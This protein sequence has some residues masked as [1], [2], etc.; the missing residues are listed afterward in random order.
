MAD[1]S[2]MKTGFDLTEPT[3]IGEQQKQIVALI[4][5]FTENALRNACVYIKHSPRTQV[6]TEDIKRGLML[7]VFLFTKRPGVVEKAKEIKNELENYENSDDDESHIVDS[8]E[9]EEEF[10]PNLCNCA[11]CTCITDIYKRWDDW[12]PSTAI[13]KILHKHINNM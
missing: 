1:Y 3:T 6:T 11:F 13:E 7:E 2:F 10:A 12:T 9:E 4:A 5:L 8:D